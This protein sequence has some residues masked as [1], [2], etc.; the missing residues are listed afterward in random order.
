MGMSASSAPTTADQLSEQPDD[1]RR[2]EV[3]DGVLFVTPAPSRVH[4]RAQMQL[5]MQLFAYAESLGLEVL[6]APTAVR[7]NATTEVQP[8]LIVLPRE[9]A[10]R[11]DAPFERM[12]DLVLAIEIVSASSARTD[13]GVKRRLY[14][15]SGVREYWVVD[16]EGRR[17][18][19]WSPDRSQM[20]VCV[21]TLTWWPVT[22]VPELVIDL[23]RFFRRVSE[24]S[25]TRKG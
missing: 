16:V 7:A 24:E 22:G 14:L 23:P 13:R 3:I 9:A 11:A 17:V 12:V 15:E 5:A 2:Y 20:E 21:G 25:S 1:G 19:R 4:Q 8:D 18:E 6:A 10:G